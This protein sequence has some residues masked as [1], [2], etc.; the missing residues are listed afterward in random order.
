[1]AAVAELGSLTSK[2]FRRLEADIFQIPVATVGSLSIIARPRGGDWLVD[3]ISM[4]AR[5]GVGPV[6]SLL[7]ED[8]QIEL[9]LEDEAASCARH[10]IEF[11]SLPVADC[12]VPSDITAFIGCF[13]RL[14][15]LVRDG[16][17][18]T[19]H[20]RQSV[21]RSG[22]LAVSIVVALGMSIDAATDVVSRTRG[23]A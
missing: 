12:G 11:V 14:A 17:S 3:D 2:S 23:V 18:V 7:C 6:V 20:C 22:L 8:E 15:C 5:R 4:L 21:G 13:Q 1:M 19:M 9:G 10:Q 16:A